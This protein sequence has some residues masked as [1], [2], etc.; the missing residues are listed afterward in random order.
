[1]DFYPGYPVWL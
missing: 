1:M